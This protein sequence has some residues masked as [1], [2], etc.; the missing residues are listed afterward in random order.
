METNHNNIPEQE[1]NLQPQAPQDQQPQED[2]DE[3]QQKIAALPE[4]RW[5][6]MLR[7]G[8][9][10]LGLLCGFLLTFFSQYDSV[11]MYGTIGAVLIA[12]FVPNIVEKRVKR[13][14]QKGRFALMI[15]LGV[16]LA[17]YLIFM[18][19]SGVPMLANPA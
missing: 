3:L 10:A 2:L 8:G 9:A 17:A 14:V 7:V 15:A 1:P 12:L 6:L 19:T 13:R 5:S 18:L 16:W 4:Q 11:G